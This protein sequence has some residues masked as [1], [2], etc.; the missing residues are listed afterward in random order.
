MSSPTV[1]AAIA[2]LAASAV[3]QWSPRGTSGGGRFPDFRDGVSPESGESTFELSGF[4]QSREEG[5]LACA[6]F[7]Q[8]SGVL[9]T[10]HLDYRKREPNW[11]QVKLG[12]RDAGTLELLHELAAAA[13]GRVTPSIIDE[14]VNPLEFDRRC[15]EVEAMFPDDSDG[16]PGLTPPSARK[17]LE[18]LGGTSDADRSARMLLAR[19]AG[20][21]AHRIRLGGRDQSTF[22]G[23]ER[24]KRLVGE[25]LPSDIVVADPSDPAWLV[26]HP[27]TRAALSDLYASDGDLFHTKRY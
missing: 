15:A 16:L 5:L 4:V 25:I 8:V 1:T 27:S 21:Y 11:I 20:M 9:G 23:M 7:D 24:L 19:F 3:V 12:C 10:A 26:V 14:A 18:A 2:S 6:L 13:G 17:V 22:E